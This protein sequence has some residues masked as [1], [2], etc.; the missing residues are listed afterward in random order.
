MANSEQ[1]TQTTHPTIEHIQSDV[2]Q[3]TAYLLHCIDL[4][5]TAVTNF[6][7]NRERS[8]KLA[9]SAA[10]AQSEQDKEKLITANSE[11]AN[12]LIG[13]MEMLRDIIESPE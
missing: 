4:L 7:Y 1:T 8:E 2:Q 10:L 9:L 5:D 6:D 11:V 3:A 12:R 13:T